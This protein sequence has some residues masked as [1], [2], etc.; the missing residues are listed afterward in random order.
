MGDRNK[1]IYN[2]FV[3]VRTDG[4]SDP[5]Q[6]HNGCNYFVL[7]LDHDPFAMPAIEAYAVACQDE[8]R[9]LATDLMRIVKKYRAGEALL[10]NDPDRR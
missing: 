2:K 5:G 6:K 3:V 1:G 9:V 7:D 8:Y 10:R 4:Q